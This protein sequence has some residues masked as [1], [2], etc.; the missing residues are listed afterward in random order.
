LVA[1]LGEIGGLSSIVFVAGAIVVGVFNE[2][3]FYSSLISISHPH[4]NYY[5]KEVLN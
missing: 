5:R 2:N 4:L 3:L 1:I